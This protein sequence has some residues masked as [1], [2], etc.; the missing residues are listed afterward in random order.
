MKNVYAFT[1][2]IVVPGTPE[3]FVQQAE[4]AV[5]ELS[6]QLKCKNGIIKKYHVTYHREDDYSVK[7]TLATNSKETKV[8]IEKLAPGE[9]FAF[10]V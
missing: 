2:C 1:L 8:R 9:T 6:W 3:V 5:I 10:Q 7:E 4:D